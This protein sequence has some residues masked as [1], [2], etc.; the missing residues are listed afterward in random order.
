[1]DFTAPQTYRVTAEDGNVRDYTVTVA[2]IADPNSGDTTDPDY[3]AARIDVFYFSGPLA[4]GVIH[5]AEKT[6]DVTVPWDTNLAAL[7][8]TI[9][10]TGAKI[11]QGSG[12]EHQENPAHIITSFA[13]SHVSPVPFTVTG[14][15][16]SPPAAATYAVTVKFADKPKS[17]ARAITV[18][19]FAGVDTAGTTAV[20][21]AVP[22][23]GGTFLIDVT[24]P[25]GT[26]ISGLTPVITHTG[27]S[28]GGPQVSSAAGP[29]TVNASGAVDFSAPQTYRVTAED[30]QT[31]DYTVTVRTDDNNAKEITGFYFTQP[32]A[33]GAI[34]QAAGTITVTVASGTNLAALRPTVFYTGVS[35]DPVSDW[36]NNFSSPTIYTVKARNGTARLYEVRV[37]PR[38]SS[39]RDIT[40][41]TFPGAPVLDTII[42]AVPGPDG[43]I[44]IS[45]VVS[46]SA[47]IGALVPNITHTGKSISPGP[48]TQDF[49]GPVSYQVTAEDGSV[50]D[51]AVSVHRLNNTSKI[52]TGLSFPVVPVGFSSVPAV[53]AID[54]ESLA[55]EVR[56]P[57]S[58]DIRGL[59]PVITWVGKSITPGGG[60]E[61][62]SHP[63][64]DSARDF[65]GPV[66]YTVTAEDGSSLEYTVT[67]EREEQNLGMTVLFQGITDTDFLNEKFDQSTGTVTVEITGDAGYASPY[68]WYL[69]GRQLTVSGTEPRLILQIA[70]MQPGQHEVTAVAKK[71]ADGKHYSNKIYFLVQEQGG[72]E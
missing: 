46:G 17:D 39:A 49:S 28:I 37:I 11:R 42:G 50:K 66:Y 54:Q 43:K 69:D 72:T 70:G 25:T 33:V 15:G 51:Y 60:V 57:R 30:G 40:A 26:V 23:S 27:V 20:I 45:I 34:D 4:I 44:P 53:A 59:A 65:T 8:P 5:E 6:I 22:D 71:I 10:Y 12:I 36:V 14:R 35:L 55:I 24:V 21:A 56:V 67:V 47:D 1:V 13:G 18:F 68:A 41:F 31:R 16:G 7:T 58:A 38:Q 48:G 62:T 63:L 64:R 61:E 52:I 2:K 29:G 9:Y 32:L 19:S 3:L